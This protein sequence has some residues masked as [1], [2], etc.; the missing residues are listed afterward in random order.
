[1]DYKACLRDGCV[2][3]ALESDTK[4]A[5]IR[6]L[7]D[8]LAAAGKIG[9]RAAVLKAVLDR[10]RQMSTGM[11]YGVAIPHA[12][13]GA[14]DRIVTAVALRPDGVDFAALDGKP[15]KIFV[16]T[17]SPTVQG[18]QHIEFLGAVSKVLTQPDVRKR[19]LKARSEGEIL[20]VLTDSGPDAGA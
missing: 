14:V 4:D 16:L 1:M 2:K 6:E 18:A 12:K 7:V 8:M 9:D 3:V 20:D 11:Q 5:I 17:L 10:E 15:S 13:T 19:L